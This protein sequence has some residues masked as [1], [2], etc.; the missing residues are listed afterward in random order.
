MCVIT[1]SDSFLRRLWPNILFSV[2]SFIFPRFDI[3][4]SITSD[5]NIYLIFVFSQIVSLFIFSKVAKA[6]VCYS[7]NK[8][9]KIF[10]LSFIFWYFYFTY[11]TH[12]I[13]ASR[14]YFWSKKTRDKGRGWGMYGN[15]VWTWRW[16]TSNTNHPPAPLPFHSSASRTVL[17]CSAA[18]LCFSTEELLKSNVTGCQWTGPQSSTR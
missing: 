4:L 10:L 9:R 14:E 5:C 8:D 13:L 18:G 2:N 7:F 3:S 12:K 17:P 11:S 16:R 1:F 6:T 15:V